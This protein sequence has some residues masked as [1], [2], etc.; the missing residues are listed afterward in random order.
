MTAFGT[1]APTPDLTSDVWY[2]HD[3][4]VRHNYVNA[5]LG[6]DW[7]LSGRNTVNL[8]WLEMVHAQ[9]VFHLNG[10][11]SFSLLRTY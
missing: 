7:V 6:V 9:D 5:G 10:A 3:Q 11:L 8:S 2:H 1:N 4:L